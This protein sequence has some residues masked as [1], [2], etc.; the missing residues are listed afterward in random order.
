MADVTMVNG[1]IID[2]ITQSGIA[3][4]YAAAAQAASPRRL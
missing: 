4:F 2:S 3:A 1:Q